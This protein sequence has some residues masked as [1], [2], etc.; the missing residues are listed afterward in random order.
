MRINEIFDPSV[1]FK[2]SKEEMLS[3]W[4]QA[5]GELAA[6]AN[7]LERRGATITAQ[8]LRMAIFMANHKYLHIKSQDDTSTN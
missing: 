5:A 3:M 6:Y 7:N 8:Q 1:D 4:P 2:F